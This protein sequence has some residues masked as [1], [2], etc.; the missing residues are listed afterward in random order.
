MLRRLA[1]YPIA[2]AAATAYAV[3]NLILDVHGVADVAVFAACLL[4]GG[5][6]AVPLALSAPPPH[7]RWRRGSRTT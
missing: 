6:I 4:I 5:A 7:G 1:T 2:F 3:V